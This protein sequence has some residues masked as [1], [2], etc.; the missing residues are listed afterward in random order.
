MYNEPYTVIRYEEDGDL[1]WAVIELTNGDRK[2]VLIR[3]QN[4]MKF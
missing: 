2:R 4:G 1:L 3:D